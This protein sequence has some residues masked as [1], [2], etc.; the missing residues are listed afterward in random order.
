MKTPED[1][2]DFPSVLRR[3]VE[4]HGDKTLLITDDRRL[5]YRE[6]DELSD[7][8]AQSLA[9]Q[10]V[11]RGEAVL[12]MLPNVADYIVIWAALAKLGAAEVP[13]NIYYKGNILR[14]VVND[15]NASRMIIDR[16][17]LERLELVSPEVDHLKQL[18]IYPDLSNDRDGTIG[19]LA[20]RFEIRSFEEVL[21]EKGVF[22]GTDS[23]NGDLIAVMYTSGTTGSSKGVAMSHAHAHQYAM[24]AVRT[25]DLS[26]SDIYYGP[27]PMFH[28]AGQWGVVY[29]SIIAGATAVIMREFHIST[30]WDEVRRFNVTATFLFGAQCNW[31]HAQPERDDDATSPLEKIITAPLLPVMDEFEKRFGVKFCT[32]YGSS[33]TNCPIQG[34]LG[35]LPNYKTCG[36]VVD[37]LYE[38]RIVDENDCEVPIGNL[39]ELVIRPKKPWITMLG[40]WNHPEWTV[41]AWRNL[42]LHTGDYFYRDGEGFYYF[43]DRKKDALRRRGENIS[44]IEV[45][46]EIN[47]HPDIVESAVIPILAEHSED[48][49]MAVVVRREGAELTYE[50][51]IRFLEPRL[52]YFMVPRFIDFVGELPRTPTGKI[53]KY[54]LR[55]TGVTSTT[56]DRE[57]AGI[58][59]AR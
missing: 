24:V 33:E 8:V 16:A 45:E 9:R 21:S 40:Y 30:F 55:E 48:D 2:W 57:S 58:R 51:L 56:W 36:K 22:T 53:A 4:I 20:K 6:L 12:I 23:E 17:Y 32:A 19:A 5:S 28:I 42:W 46:N 49:V 13:I 43:A 25:L 31:L 3:Q 44:S 47:A 38:V 54:P 50:A 7:M 35:E 11:M 37:E 59:L 41:G 14:H 52:P 34:K 15:S 27:L 10:G 1:K 39:G 18:I 29:A 26:E